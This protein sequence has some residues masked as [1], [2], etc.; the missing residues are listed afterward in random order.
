M[1]ATD[2]SAFALFILHML[3]VLFVRRLSRILYNDNMFVFLFVRHLSRILYNKN[4][5]CIF[6]E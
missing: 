5:Y 6:K 2:L 1:R 4:R 3:V